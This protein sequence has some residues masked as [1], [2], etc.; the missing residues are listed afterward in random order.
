MIQAGKEVAVVVNPQAAEGRAGRHWPVLE[1]RLKK[2]LGAFQLL[3]TEGPGHGSILVRTALRAGCGRIISVGG[4]GTHFEVLNGFFEGGLPI[5]PDAEMAV[6]PFGTGS[7]LARSL[8]IPQGIDAAAFAG[9][10]RVLRTDVGCITCTQADGSE[11]TW[12]FQNIARIG[13]GGEVVDRVNHT[14]KRFGGFVSYLVGT[15]SS[16]LIYRDQ[17]VR[18]AID[19]AEIGGLLKEFI[20][21]NGSYDGGGMHVAPH[22]RMD[23]GLFDIYHIGSVGLLDALLNLPKIYRGRLHKRPDVVKYLRGRRITAESAFPIKVEADGEM[24]G[25]LPARVEVLPGAI[26]LVT[27]DRPRSAVAPSPR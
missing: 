3:R 17:E 9:S 10:A 19:D 14:T 1:A 12:Y 8:G 4:D 25:Y 7:D 2:E 5:Q 6:I 16:L 11:R 27:G 24:L 13:I 22:A 15:L 21:A 23:N 26:T 18:F 20:I